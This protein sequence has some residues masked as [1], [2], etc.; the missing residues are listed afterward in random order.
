MPSPVAH[1]LVSM[2]LVAPK[3]EKEPWV[4]WVGFWVVMGNFADL[5]FIPGIL[6]GAPSRFHHGLSH[7]LLFAVSLAVVAYLLYPAFFK[8]HRAACWPFLAVPFS[9]LFLDMMT[10]DTV[11]PYGLPLFWPFSHHTVRFPFWVFLNMNRGTRFHILFSWHNL[12][13]LCL[14]VVLT[15]PFFAWAMSRRD[16]LNLLKPAWRKVVRDARRW[17]RKKGTV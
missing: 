5:D 13:A 12:A 14:E 11:A 10:R 3:P 15:F 6:I 7:S 8:G 9:H 1:S 4:K 17:I 2:A 16:G